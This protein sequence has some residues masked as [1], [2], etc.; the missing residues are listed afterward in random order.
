VTYA[1]DK[2]QSVAD[3]I[4]PEH[5]EVRALL[6]PHSKLKSIIKTGGEKTEIL[7][8]QVNDV[9]SD[10]DKTNERLQ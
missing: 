9:E 3:L 2:Q 8:Q 7:S 10:K 1:F 6:K 5:S 4:D